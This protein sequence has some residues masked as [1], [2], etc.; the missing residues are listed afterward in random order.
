MCPAVH[1]P[2][3]LVD[4]RHPLY[5]RKEIDHDNVLVRK[6]SSMLTFGLHVRRPKGKVITEQLHYQRRVLIAVLA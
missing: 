2:D 1:Y 3:W 5:G 6:I 4:H